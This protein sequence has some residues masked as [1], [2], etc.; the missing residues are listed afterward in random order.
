MPV[1]WTAF[2]LL[3]FAACLIAMAVLPY[4][5]WRTPETRVALVVS[6]LLV[7]G[8]LTLA[9]L[10]FVRSLFPHQH[11]EG[12]KE[13]ASCVTARCA[14]W[15]TGGTGTYGVGACSI[16]CSRKEPQPDGKAETTTVVV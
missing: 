2:F 5:L 15:T 11:R 8:F 1:P 6:V 3:A 9:P 14:Y 13:T 10:A 12:V 4:I 7:Y 16:R